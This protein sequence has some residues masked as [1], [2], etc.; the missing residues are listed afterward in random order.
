MEDN[1]IQRSVVNL[2]TLLLVLFVGLKL[3]EV[4]VVA[5][6]SWFWVLSPLWILFAALAVVVVGTFIV[7]FVVSVW[8]TLA[9]RQARKVNEKLYGKDR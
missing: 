2:F 1:K 5:N 4:G 3:A 6:W 8:D 9:A 7:A